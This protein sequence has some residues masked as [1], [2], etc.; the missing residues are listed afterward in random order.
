MPDEEAHIDL[1]DDGAHAAAEIPGTSGHHQPGERAAVVDQA[2]DAEPVKQ[3]QKV[4]VVVPRGDHEAYERTTQR[5]D[6]EQVR[7]A[8]ASVIVQSTRPPKP[9]EECDT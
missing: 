6:A 1:L 7:S 4:T 5:L 3:A 2:L 9:V 8:G